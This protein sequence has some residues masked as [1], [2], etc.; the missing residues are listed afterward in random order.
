[1]IC[2]GCLKGLEMPYI[3]NVCNSCGI[4]LNLCLGCLC[5]VC[6][7]CVLIQAQKLNKS[8]KKKKKK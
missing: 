2:N 6:K 4:G 8:H 5:E 3:V 1:M 7:D